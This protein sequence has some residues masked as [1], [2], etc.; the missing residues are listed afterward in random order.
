MSNV[1]APKRAQD[2]RAKDKSKKRKEHS[3]F[4][5]TAWTR[6]GHSDDR[7]TDAGGR[8][9]GRRGGTKHRKRVVNAAM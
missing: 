7:S 1:Y 8:T 9:D 3:I 2:T 4:R 6:S 5:P